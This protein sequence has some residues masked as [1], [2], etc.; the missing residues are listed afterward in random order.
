MAKILQMWNASTLTVPRN[1]ADLTV[2]PGWGVTI[3]DGVTVPAD[4][5][6]SFSF[7]IIPRISDG[8]IYKGQKS[9]EFEA[10]YGPISVEIRGADV[11]SGG[12][13]ASMSTPGDEVTF[14]DGKWIAVSDTSGAGYSFGEVVQAKPGSIV[15]LFRG[16]GRAKE[17]AR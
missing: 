2:M 7:I 13:I 3:R 8:Q 17:I 12:S 4:Q 6:D 14:S 16:T 11:A 15:I 9:S 5:T 1:G 10:I